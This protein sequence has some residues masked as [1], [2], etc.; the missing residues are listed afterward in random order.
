MPTRRALEALLGEPFIDGN[1]VRVLRNGDGVFPALLAAV[2]NAGRSVDLLWFVWEPGPI[3]AELADALAE[4]ARHGV[5]VRLLLDAFGALHADRNQIRAL[6]AAGCTVA[7]HHPLLTW[8]LT[9]VNRRLHQRVLICDEKLAFT[10]GIGVG[11]LYTGDAQDPDHYRDTV[12]EVRGP[13]VVGLRGTFARA[14]QQT[15]H[16]LVTAADHF[17]PT[18]PAGTSAVHVMRSSSEPGW[19]DAA[20]ALT[21]LL[22]VASDRIRFSTPYVRLASR[23]HRHLAAAVARDVQVQVVLTGPHPAR[24]TVQWQSDRHVQ[25]LLDTGVEVF[26]YQ[27][28]LMHAKVV[29]VDQ[30]ISMVGTANLDQ[31]SLTINQQVALVVD[32]PALTAELDADFDLDLARSRR[33]DPARWRHRG[34]LRRLRAA[35]ADRVAAPLRGS[36]GEGLTV[37][38]R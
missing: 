31:R 20:L 16:P 18:P 4:R 13:A 29:T 19:N 3:T 8:R 32:D 15:P 11:Q 1:R 33:L 2:R 28:T 27:P 37:P 25:R 23:F 38:G 22:Q 9:T 7:F 14:W 24:P 10:G 30:R 6:R 35:L 5:R 17:P 26:A 36:G 21:A 34:Q 12:L